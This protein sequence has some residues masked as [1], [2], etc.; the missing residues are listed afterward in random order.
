MTKNKPL[1]KICGL[2]SQSAVNISVNA[3]ADMLGFVFFEASPRS[4]S[5]YLRAPRC[6]LQVR[7][8]VPGARQ[9]RC[10]RVPG[11]RADRSHATPLGWPIRE[12]FSR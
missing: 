6:G 9:A 4:L 7:M 11:Q 3:G 2:T 12:E 8:E 5:L 1:V 10:R